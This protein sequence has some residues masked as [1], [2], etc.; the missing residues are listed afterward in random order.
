MSKESCFRGPFDR[1]HGQG[2]QTLLKHEPKHLY[3][4]YWSPLRQL[5]WKKWL[6]VIFKYS[7]LYRGNLKEPIQLQLS[8]K[9]NLFSQF[10]AAILKS[11]LNFE[12]SQKRDNPHSGICGL[13]KMC[14]AKSKKKSN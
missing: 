11:R 2:D 4:I 10:V 6:L 9:Q 12:H 14:L 5:R 8:Q 7:L 13:R 3:H 1:Q